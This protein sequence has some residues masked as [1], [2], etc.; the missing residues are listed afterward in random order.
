MNKS[1]KLNNNHF[2]KYIQLSQNEISFVIT[3]TI[4]K[5][6]RE[7]IS[8][9]LGMRISTGVFR[10]KLHHI[11]TYEK[12]HKYILQL[13]DDKNDYNI[14]IVQYI[15][16]DKCNMF[17]TD[18]NINFYKGQPYELKTAKIPKHIEIRLKQIDIKKYLTT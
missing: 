2:K 13:T 15:T 5:R 10:W 17:V 4:K 6:Q 9:V 14:F 18:D 8:Y 11:E 1:V 7:N 12:I 3:E 16:Q